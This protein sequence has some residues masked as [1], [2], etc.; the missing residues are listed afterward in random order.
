M[1]KLLTMLFGVFFLTAG[2]G[3]VAA[4]TGTANEAVALVKK[5]AAFVKQSGKDKALAEFNNPQGA[6]VDRDLYIF[7]I[8][9]DGK[10]LANGFN[11]KVV[12]KN[13][14]EMKDADGKFFIKHFIEI[15]QAKGS[16]WS[17]YQ[18][19]DPV[20]KTIRPKSTYVEKVGDIVIGCGIYK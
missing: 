13:V 19:P 5:A 18:W 7:V 14:I 1:K 3:A 20:T 2:I 8:D 11:Q 10:T 15:A 12:G 16:G 9:M 17:D 4:E 6:F